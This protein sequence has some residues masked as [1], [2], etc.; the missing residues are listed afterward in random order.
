M[1]RKCDD[2]WEMCRKC[3]NHKEMW[4]KSDNHK[5][6][7]RNVIKH[8][9]CNATTRLMGFQISE[10]FEKMRISRKNQNFNFLRRES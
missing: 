10:N 9:K 2:I 6:M 1:C 8:R 5:N 7:C 3:D 4:W